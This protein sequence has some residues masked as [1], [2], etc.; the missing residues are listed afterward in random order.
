MLDFIHIVLKNDYIIID[1]F[2]I[3]KTE[4][5]FFLQIEIS[6]IWLASECW[7][8]IQESR[9]RLGSC[10]D[11]SAATVGTYTFGDASPAHR[12]H[13][14]AVAGAASSTARARRAASAVMHPNPPKSWPVKKVATLA[15]LIKIH[16][17]MVG[18]EPMPKT[19]E[20]LLK[21]GQE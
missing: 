14:L 6:V 10:W 5:F 21:L 3:K 12:T 17:Y 20:V 9:T 8:S 11:V 2:L 13:S 1:V 15:F 18:F 19:S 16:L 7:E 4:L